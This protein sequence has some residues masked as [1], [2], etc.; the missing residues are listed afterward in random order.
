MRMLLIWDPR[1]CLSIQSK[2]SSNLNLHKTLPML[3][4]LLISPNSITTINII[5]M[6]SSSLVPCSHKSPNICSILPIINNPNMIIDLSDL[7][8]HKA[9]ISYQSSQ[10]VLLV[11]TNISKLIL[12]LQ[13]DTN[14]TGL[15]NREAKMKEE[16]LL[17]NM[18]EW[19][20][21]TLQ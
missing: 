2:V 20:N 8:I 16:L 13:I 15:L 10:L 6:L 21:S 3:L 17:N 14:T 9:P 18:E 7:C 19:D 4:L 12:V 11:V 1:A 5:K